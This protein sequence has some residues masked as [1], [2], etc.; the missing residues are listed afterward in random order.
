MTDV[1]LQETNALL[2]LTG[3]G[4]RIFRA[5]DE[6]VASVSSMS[7]ALFERLFDL[8]LKGVVREPHS[9]EDYCNNAQLVIDAL[10][11]AVLTE[12]LSHVNG[13]LVCD[14]DLKSIRELV[15]VLS[16]VYHML[17]RSRHDDASSESDFNQRFYVKKTKKTTKRHKKQTD[18]NLLSTQ[19]Y[20][21]FVPIP[22]SSMQ[23]ARSES[24]ASSDSSKN[25]AKQ[26]PKKN[27]LRPSDNTPPIAF[28]DVSSVSFAG[29]ENGETMEGTGLNV[30][31]DDI[32]DKEDAPSPIAFD[33]IPSEHP[34]Q[35]L[36][37]VSSSL[38]IENSEQDIERISIKPVPKPIKNSREIPKVHSSRLQEKKDHTPRLFQHSKLRLEDMEP[39]TLLG[40]IILMGFCSQNR[41]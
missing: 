38:H 39:V 21:R 32:S 10:A 31:P 30:A 9:H 15:R 8:R 14:G 33:I 29:S 36:L 6:L 34:Q 5:L 37:A 7:V 18:T 40:L 23:S 3:F 41:R 17:Q 1:V 26:K 12:D 13:Q 2:R 19:K 11:E 24:S 27:Q 4:D 35:E 22:R 16:H 20:G 28:A 25:K